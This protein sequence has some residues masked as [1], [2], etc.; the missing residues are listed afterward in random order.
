M[1]PNG[2]PAV[3]DGRRRCSVHSV[4]VL[5]VVSRWQLLVGLVVVCRVNRRISAACAQGAPGARRVR[6]TRVPVAVAVARDPR[7]RVEASVQQIRTLIGRHQHAAVGDHGAVARGTGR[8]QDGRT[9]FIVASLR[10]A[11]EEQEHRGNCR[12]RRANIVARPSVL[13]DMLGLPLVTEGA[14]ARRFVEEGDQGNSEEHRK[15]LGGL[16]EA[17]RFGKVFRSDPFEREHFHRVPKAA[18]SQAVQ[19]GEETEIPVLGHQGE[20][21]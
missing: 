9:W 20:H 5:L 1:F 2:T 19:P 3:A 8:C 13:Q 16:D 12:G 11:D 10:V 15:R 14:A 6:R 17:P 21:E 4:A 7:R 18:Q